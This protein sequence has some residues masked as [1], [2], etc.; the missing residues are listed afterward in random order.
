MALEILNHATK[1]RGFQIV[2]DS[3]KPELTLYHLAASRGLVKFIKKIFKEKE[4]HKLDVNCPN[5][6]G[7]TPLYLAKLFNFEFK[8]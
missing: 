6:D 3:R 7:I 8:I 2:C 1:T 5:K 4:Q